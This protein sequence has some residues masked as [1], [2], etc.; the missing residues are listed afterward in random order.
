MRSCTRHGLEISA[1]AYYPNNLHPDDAYREEAH[2]HLRKVIAAARS[3]RRRVV[4]TFIGH[5]RDRPLTDTS[6]FRAI[7]RRSSTMQASAA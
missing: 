6:A 7:C 4:G 1:L 3:A 5:D 2:G